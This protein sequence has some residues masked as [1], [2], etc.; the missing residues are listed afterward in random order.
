MKLIK[1]GAEIEDLWYMIF[2]Y[3]FYLHA[4]HSLQ[5]REDKNTND[6]PFAE[7]QKSVEKL[8]RSRLLFHQTL[9]CSICM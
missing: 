5:L 6:H 8:S 4:S 2:G 7:L 1:T 3:L 9:P